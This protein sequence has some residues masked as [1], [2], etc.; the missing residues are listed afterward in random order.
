MAGSSRAYT[1]GS[2]PAVVGN[3]PS[4]TPKSSWAIGASTMIGMPMTISVR[5]SVVLSKTLPRRRPASTP[6]ATPKTTANAMASAAS[7]MVTGQ[8]VA[9]MSE[10]SRPVSVLAQ[11]AGEQPAHVVRVLDQERLVE[12]VLRGQQ[13]AGSRR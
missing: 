1:L 6:A 2:A 9:I 12:V 11:V 7:L 10:I 5:T 13:L 8:A 3:Q 4:L